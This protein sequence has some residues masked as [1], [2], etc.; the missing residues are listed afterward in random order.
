[1]NKREIK[2]L[3]TELLCQNAFIERGYNVSVPISPYCVYDFIV[4]INK[5][6]Y[7]IQVKSCTQSKMGFSI[8]T[9]STH[10]AKDKTIIRKYTKEDIDYVCTYYNNN[11]YLIPTNDI[12]N[13][14]TVTL[15]LDNKRKNGYKMMLATDYLIDRQIKDISK[16]I[17]NKNV[18]LN[19]AL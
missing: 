1:M 3:T 19:N 6:M 2:G 15:L 16:N 8:C 13:R 11:C 9:K 4:D 10:L 18:L 17:N 12:E 7:R 5:N 14:T